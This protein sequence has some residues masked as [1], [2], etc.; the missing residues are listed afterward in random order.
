MSDYSNYVAEELEKSR[1]ALKDAEKMQK[2]SVSDEAIVSRLYYALFH[3]VKAALYSKDLNPKTHAGLV[4]QF[5]EHL[6][7]E[8]NITKEDAKFIS[9][10][11]TRR[12]EA[13]YDYNPE[14]E[15]DLENIFR[16]TKQIIQKMEKLTESELN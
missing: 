7:E 14:I 6:L 2:A 10:S 11:Q 15:E 12:E 9:I 3:S 13:D 8:D 16:Q 4:S 5:G 1:R